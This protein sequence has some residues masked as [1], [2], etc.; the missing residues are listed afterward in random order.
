M[1]E[2]YFARPGP[3]LADGLELLTALLHPAFEATATRA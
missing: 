2:A 3:R 1:P